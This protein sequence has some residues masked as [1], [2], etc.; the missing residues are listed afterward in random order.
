MKS[1][2]RHGAPKIAVGLALLFFLLSLGMATD[3]TFERMLI[4]YHNNRSVNSITFDNENTYLASSGGLFIYNNF[5]KLWEIPVSESQGL[6]NPNII[7]VLYHPFTGYIW[8]LTGDE[9]YVKRGAFFWF[10]DLVPLQFH[11]DKL[12]YIDDEL[13][14]GNG[15]NNYQLDPY[16]GFIQK[17]TGYATG[18]I[19]WSTGNQ[20]LSVDGVN[21]PGSF[22]ID[23]NSDLV[24]QS[25]RRF[26]VTFSAQD[27]LMNIWI[28]TDG[29]GVFAGDANMMNAEH[30][31]YGLLTDNVTDICGNNRYIAVAGAYDFNEKNPLS[32]VTIISE[33]FQQFRWVT[34]DEISFLAQSPINSLV[35]S[36]DSAYYAIGSTIILHA[37]NQNQWEF[38]MQGAGLT[39]EIYELVKGKKSIW[40]AAQHGLFEIDRQS[41]SIRPW[42]KGKDFGVHTVYTALEN[43]SMLYIGGEF[44]IIQLSLVEDHYLEPQAIEPNVTSGVEH[45]SVHDDMILYSGGSDLYQLQKSN[46]RGVRF[47]VSPWFIS[48]PI[49]SLAANDK[50]MWVGTDNGLFEYHFRMRQWRQISIEQGLPDNHIRKLEFINEILYIGTEKGMTKYNYE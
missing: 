28:G 26:P 33:N 5:S 40:V 25:G 2:L 17:E 38:I 43:D 20:L 37:F 46:M 10:W 30:K 4:N 31:P 3:I 19:F 29:F 36:G 50:Y 7:S 48:A 11:L 47:I 12:G 1:Q 22:L 24:T 35:L 21:L 41:L 18:E 9:L 14:G 39:G 32:G 15:D 45:I 16:F 42:F 27:Q 6:D 23:G 49:L 8:A 13:I 44:G 34:S